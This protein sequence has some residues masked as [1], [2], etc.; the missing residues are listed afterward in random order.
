MYP[1]RNSRTVRYNSGIGGQSRNSYFAQTIPELSRFLHCAEHI[2]V[3]V[4]SHLDISNLSLCALID[5]TVMR[6]GQ[7]PHLTKDVVNNGQKNM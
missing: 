4:F 5:C 6:D 1:L 7:D 3:Y 2:Y